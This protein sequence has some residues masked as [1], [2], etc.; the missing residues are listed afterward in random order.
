MPYANNDGIKIHYE[1]EGKGLSVILQHG[2]GGSLESWY[3]NGYV[4]GLNQDY[5][6]ILV[7]GRGHGASDK[8]HDPEAYRA[9][10]IAGDYTTIMDDLKLNKVIY[11]GYSMGGNIGWR[12]IARYALPRVSAF[13]LGG[14]TPYGYT[15]QAEKDF[16]EGITNAIRE[17]E[18][19]GPEAWVEYQIKH[20]PPMTPEHKARLL[21]NSD[22]SALLAHRIASIEMWPSAADLLLQIKI[23]CFVFVGE[24]DAYFPKNKEAVKVLPNA[25]FVSF[26]GHNHGETSRDSAVVLPHVKKFLAEVSKNLP[27][28][29]YY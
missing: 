17:A 2:F 19:R 6:L 10:I 11:Y 22:P 1:I 25:K 8:P 28:Y 15:T 5:R 4:E 27:L 21:R 14:S 23:P 20:G 16:G 7:D 18:K 26:P 24:N 9:D 29:R 12:C 13:I 3:D